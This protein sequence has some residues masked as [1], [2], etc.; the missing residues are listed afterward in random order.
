CQKYTNT[1][2]TF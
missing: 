2:F 1:P